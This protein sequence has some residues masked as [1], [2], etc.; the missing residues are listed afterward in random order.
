MASSRLATRA[1]QPIA[2]VVLPRLSAPASFG[3][4]VAAIANRR[5]NS[6]SPTSAGASSSGASPKAP[7][8]EPKSNNS[9]GLILAA[10]V[11]AGGS[12]YAYQKFSGPTEDGL[13]SFAEQAT[14][15]DYQKVYNAI[16]KRLQDVDDEPDEGSFGP[17]LVRLAWHASGTFDKTSHTGGSG[18]GTMRFKQEVSTGAN[19]GLIRA[20]NW[21]DPI[22]KQFPWISHGD[23]Y[24]LSGVTAIQELGGP[25]IKW[26]AGRVDGGED[27][28]P[29][30]GRLP[31]ASK[32][33]DHIRDLFVKRMG[34]TE[35]ETVALI[36]AHALGR[37]H[38]QYSGFDGPWTFSPTYFT[39]D[40][41]KLLVDEKWHVRKWDGPKQYEDDKTKSLMML[42]ADYALVQD[43]DLK[44]WVH[45]YAED[46]DFF[47]QEFARSFST[48]LELG[49]NFKPNTQY[50]EFTRL[51]D[52]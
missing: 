40:F 27:R 5:Y 46:N 9:L 20:R 34:F 26:R 7:P 41:F 19:S 31:D 18:Y 38:P 12:W 1:A 29:P 37:C 10:A 44:K 25:T 11:V 16:A 14:K 50:F 15:D 33:G 51:D 49:V 48:L 13:A 6:S 47:F 36:G 21:L 35:G 30:D 22:H 42:P 2:R 17:V 43:K 4:A 8:P 3:A 32:G 28:V 23:L 45:K 39:N 52:Q 24:T